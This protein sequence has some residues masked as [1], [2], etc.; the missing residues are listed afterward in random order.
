MG[1]KHIE[2]Y[3]SGV[4]LTDILEKKLRKQSF[5]ENKLLQREILL[6]E[7]ELRKF[8]LRGGSLREYKRGWKDIFSRVLRRKSCETERVSRLSE[9]HS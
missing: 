3:F 8:F 5:R 7:G 6:R 9:S 1:E 4:G 2:R